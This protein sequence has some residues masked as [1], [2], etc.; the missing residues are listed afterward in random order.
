[1][2]WSFASVGLIVLGLIG[3]AIIVLF[4]QVTTTNESDYYLLKEV[5]EAAMIDAI[6]LSYYRETGDLKIIK[7]KII[8]NFI[9]RYAESIVFASNEYTIKS[10]DI[11]E[12][13]PKVSVTIDTG[14]EDY[15]IYGNTD[16]YSVA[17]KLDAILEYVGKNTNSDDNPYILH[18]SNSSQGTPLTMTYYAMISKNS[19]F[20]SYSGNFSLKLPD[21]LNA[22]NI[23]DIKIEQVSYEGEVNT[24]AELNEAILKDNLFYV[25]GTT[26]Y[27]QFIDNFAT[28]VSNVTAIYH[29]C[30][31][32]IDNFVCNKD[33][34]YWVNISGKTTDINKEKVILK[35]EVVW[36][37]KEYEFS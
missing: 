28:D 1:M 7:E 2:K 29:N 10:Y 32:S 26:N 11:I 23:K 25:N 34:S 17:N 22:P 20:D 5:T 12:T 4:Q 37:Y 19:G 24:Q 21:E 36:S 31:N 6:D 3:V 14:L 13:P 18:S 30:G 9:R 35:Y 33:N 8:E 27:L 16:D 15:T